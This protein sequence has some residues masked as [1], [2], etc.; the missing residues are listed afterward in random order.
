MHAFHQIQTH[1]YPIASPNKGTNIDQETEYKYLDF[2][3]WWKINIE[4]LLSER[5]LVSLINPLFSSSL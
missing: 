5:K 2:L 3:D 1:K 4:Y